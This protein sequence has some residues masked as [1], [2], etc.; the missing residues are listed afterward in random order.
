M[1]ATP[2]RL[3]ERH[4]GGRGLLLWSIFIPNPLGYKSRVVGPLS[5]TKDHFGGAGKGSGG[6]EGEFNGE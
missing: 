1:V 6:F 3:F 4:E 5:A 2:G